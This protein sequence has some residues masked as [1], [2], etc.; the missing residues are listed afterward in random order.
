MEKKIKRI[1]MRVRKV[2]I[3]HAETVGYRSDLGGMCAVA[4]FTLSRMLCREGIPAYPVVGY[5]CGE[6][7]CWVEVNGK[8]VDITATQFR[9]YEDKP[10]LTFSLADK[11]YNHY[12]T[13]EVMNTES[14]DKLD[15]WPPEQRPFEDLIVKLVKKLQSSRRPTVES[16]H[17][18][19]V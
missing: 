2:M 15:D 7:H 6:G 3:A 4:S 1:A 14:T 5:C 17:L 13:L 18:K 16:A 10:Y 12:E 19:R 8:V 11:E 9:E